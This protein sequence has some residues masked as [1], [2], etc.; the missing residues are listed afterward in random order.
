MNNGILKVSEESKKTIE[1]IGVR[2]RITIQGESFVFGNAAIEKCHE[3]KLAVGKI[4]AIDAEASIAVD[5]VTIQS[6]TGWFTKASKGNYRVMVAL[7][8]MSKVNDVLG[9]IM[10]LNNV[11]M[12]S[13]EWDYDDYAAKVLLIEESVRRCKNKAEVM[14]ATLGKTIVGIKTCADSYTVPDNDIQ[15]QMHGGQLDYLSP[16]TRVRRSIAASGDFGSEVKGK[17]E[18]SAVATIEFY[19]SN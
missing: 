5:G 2:L 16:E 1:A 7:S 10:E 18:I 14:A 17:K 12:D 8:D 9:A 6:E 4:I 13:L 19:L 3:V 11:S 15:T